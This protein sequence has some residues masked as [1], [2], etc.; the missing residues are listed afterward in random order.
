MNRFLKSTLQLACV[1]LAAGSITVNAKSSAT[2]DIHNTVVAKAAKSEKG[3]VMVFTER[4]NA[5]AEAA[6]LLL[7]QVKQ[8]E[9]YE[10]LLLAIESEKISGYKAALGL[11]N[12]ALPAVIFF[13]KTGEEIA[14][15]V[16]AKSS[17]TRPAQTR[18][19]LA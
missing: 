5:A 14:R 9:G 13:D 11:P 17:M 1:V 3:V 18:Y 4:G 2:L 16:P 19:R 6:Y 15:V 12:T 8:N 7:A 10:P